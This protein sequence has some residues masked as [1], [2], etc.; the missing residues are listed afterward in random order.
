[1]KVRFKGK[2]IALSLKGV[3]M[4]YKKTGQPTEGGAY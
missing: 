1:M 2:I 4:M 3:E